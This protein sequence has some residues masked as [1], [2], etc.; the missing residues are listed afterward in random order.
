MKAIILA[1]CSLSRR[2]L[3]TR[4]ELPFEAISPDVDESPL[5]T[6]KPADLALRLAIAKASIF[7]SRYPD[8][9]IIGSDQVLFCGETRL[10]KP[11]TVENAIDQLKCVSEKYVDSYTALAVLNT[12]TEKLQSDVIYTRVYFRKLTDKIIQEYIRRDNPL[13]CAG[14]IKA[15]GLGMALF[16]KIETDDPTAILG[17][18]LITLTTMLMQEGIDLWT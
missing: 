16:T 8:S 1:S 7:R 18:P 5:P 14:S 6:E 10:D 2:S 4:L 11:E 17:L 9:L 12:K 13:H 3:L 15:E